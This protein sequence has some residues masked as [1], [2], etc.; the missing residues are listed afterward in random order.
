MISFFSNLTCPD[1][2]AAVLRSSAAGS[3]TTV[4]RLAQ[5]SFQDLGL[6]QSRFR[7]LVVWASR[8]GFM[9]A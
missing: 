7:N 5:A 1:I 2:F 9:H 6:G 4:K 3:A 8:S